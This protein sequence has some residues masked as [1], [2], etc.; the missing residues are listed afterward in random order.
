MSN[1][2]CPNNSIK[3]TQSADYSH[4]SYSSILY[5]NDMYVKHIICWF[6]QSSKR[7]ILSIDDYYHRQRPEMGFI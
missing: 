4:T 7:V 3:I 6:A 1:W 5:A 2:A